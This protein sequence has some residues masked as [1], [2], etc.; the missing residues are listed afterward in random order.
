MAM[1]AMPDSATP[2]A[3]RLLAQHGGVGHLMA[4]GTAFLLPFWG[5]ACAAALRLPW[6]RA[7]GGLQSNY[8]KRAGL[9]GE[10]VWVRLSTFRFI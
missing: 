10:K 2:S 6:C 8:R 1:D 9:F 5:R 7:M 3:V 4:R